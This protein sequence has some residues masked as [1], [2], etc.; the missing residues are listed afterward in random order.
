MRLCWKFLVAAVFAFV[1]LVFPRSSRAATSVSC[2]TQAELPPQDRD[3]LA[4]TGGRLAEAIVQQ[5]YSALQAALLPAEAAEWAGIR[6]TVEHA[7]PLV[8]GGHMQLRSVYLLDATALAATG[9]TQFF[10]SN[11]TGSLTVTI[12][13]RSLPPGRYAV[14][15]ADAAGA[16]LGGQMGII[17]A[18]D[19]TG[20]TA[21]WK[22][23]GLSVRQGVFDGHDGVW[24][25][26][27]ARELAKAGLPW[28]AWYCYEAARSL[29]VPVDFISSPNLEKLAAEQ[30]QIK[31]SPQ[32]AFPYSLAD[33]PRTWKIDAVRLDASLRQP[34]LGVT[35]ES[36]GVTDP[37]AA[38]TEAVA[39]LSALLK[40]Q[41]DLRQNFHGLWAYAMKDGKLTPVIELPMGQ[42][43]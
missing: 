12:T 23:A 19:P 17:L 3:A 29:L 16:A 11:S 22:L 18:W 32:D 1:V 13:M 30:A 21:A 39:V 20:A 37:A 27:H 9:D 15:L 24:Y 38:R 34:D 28:S 33:G 14:V 31:G 42:I 6:G 7:A 40:A 2:A 25:W 5:D 41:P 43:P 8:K 4:A 36:V 26:T 10:C 35:Y